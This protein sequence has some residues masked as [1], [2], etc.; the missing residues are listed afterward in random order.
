MTTEARQDARTDRVIAA[1][2]KTGRTFVGGTTRRGMRCM[3]ISM[4]IGQTDEAAV[5]A[6]V[7]AFA[8]VLEGM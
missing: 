6:D 3:R 7:S 4:C 1:V 8:A 2:V 5:D